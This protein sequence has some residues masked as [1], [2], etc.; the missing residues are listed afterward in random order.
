MVAYLL[1]GRPM[2]IYLKALRCFG[3]EGVML[4]LEPRYTSIQ[5][6]EKMSRKDGDSMLF[7]RK[8]VQQKPEAKLLI[9]VFF[10]YSFIYVLDTDMIRSLS[11]EHIHSMT[12]KPFMFF[13][14]ME[15][16][17]LFSKEIAWKKS[18]AI[19]S[20]LFHF[21]V[22]KSREGIM[23]KVVDQATRDLEKSSVN[24][25]DLGLEISGEITLQSFLGENFAQI[26]FGG[27]RVLGEIR[28]IIDL[29]VEHSIQP[30]WIVRLGVTGMDSPPDWLL[31]KAE[32]NLRERILRFKTLTREFLKAEH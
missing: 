20:N 22:L 13:K 25:F 14:H 11:N 21:D 28:E 3:K 32:I 12:K 10:F 2:L 24:L 15:K 6:Y 30:W 29:L 9:V 1:I 16:G 27:K 4:V 31:R 19:L 23:N 5:L 17:L 8:K 26:R 7:L 18:R